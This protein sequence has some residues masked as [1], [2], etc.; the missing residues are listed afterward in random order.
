MAVALDIIQDK[1]AQKALV[2]LAE[3]DEVKLHITKDFSN[4]AHHMLGKRINHALAFFRED[5][6]NRLRCHLSQNHLSQ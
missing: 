6:L 5:F 4:D 1:K 3:G 2:G